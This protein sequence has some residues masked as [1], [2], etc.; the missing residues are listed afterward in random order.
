MASIVAPPTIDDKVLP[1]TPSHEWANDT[2]DAA[3]QSNTA[4]MDRIPINS[5][6]ST[7]GLEFPGAFPRDPRGQSETV[8]SSSGGGGGGGGGGHAQEGSSVLDTAKQYIPAQEDVQKV[9]KNVGETAKQYLPQTIVSYFPGSEPTTTTSLPSQENDELTPSGGVGSLPGTASESSVAVL[10]DERNQ[11][12]TVGTSTPKPTAATDLPAD[13]SVLTPAT[14]A[15]TRKESI[16]NV[17]TIAEIGSDDGKSTPGFTPT[18]STNPSTTVVPSPPSNNTGGVGDLPGSQTESSVA[19]LPEE[20]EKER[21]TSSSGPPE[22]QSQGSKPLNE[23]SINLVPRTHPLAADGAEWKGVALDE[24]TQSH[25]D[26]D[27]EKQ[28][29]I[30]TISKSTPIS[31]VS[32]VAS[33]SSI[34]SSSSTSATAAAAG[35]AATASSPN[36]SQSRFTEDDPVNSANNSTNNVT[37]NNKLATGGGDSTAAVSEKSSSGKS[38]GSGS[39]GGGGKK[40]KFLDKVKGE[41]KIIAGKLGGKEEKVEEGKRLMGK[42]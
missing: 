10:P 35:A 24:K 42:V 28:L 3:A 39:E 38:S 15:Q 41:V 27:P 40:S 33:P 34:S 2:L 30:G 32:S 5:T 6:T 9:L 16:S 25:L 19:V 8:N 18:I 17:S 29:N 36:A 4:T 21:N 23:P 31:K 14:N 7:P 37:T 26:N 12:A 13:T 11:D 1:S 20:T 22:Q